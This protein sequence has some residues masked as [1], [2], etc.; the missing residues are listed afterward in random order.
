MITT[1]VTYLPC[2]LW[3]LLGLPYV[4][5]L[6]RVRVLNTAMSII[7]ATVAGVMFHWAAFLRHIPFGGVETTEWLGMRLLVP[8]GPSIN[9]AAC[10]VSILGLGPTFWW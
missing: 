9:V 6:R 7:T 8:V 10:A 4:E 1:W 2:F 5:R 3:V